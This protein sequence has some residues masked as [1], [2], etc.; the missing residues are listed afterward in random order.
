MTRTTTA[1]QNSD[2]ERPA[3]SDRAAQ[4]FNAEALKK[5][6]EPATTSSRTFDAE[7]EQDEDVNGNKITNDAEET[8]LDENRNDNVELDETIKIE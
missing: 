3:Q 5:V 1:T 8:R 6:V 7:E 2:S 4:Y